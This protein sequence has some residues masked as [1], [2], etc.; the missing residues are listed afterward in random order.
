M[1]ARF[2]W[3]LGEDSR[4]DFGSERNGGGIPNGPRI[5]DKVIGNDFSLIRINNAESLLRYFSGYSCEDH[6]YESDTFLH[7][8]EVLLQLLTAPLCEN[9]MIDVGMPIMHKNVA[10]NCRVIFLNQKILLIR[11]KL[12]MCDDGNYRESRWF[13][14]WRKVIMMFDY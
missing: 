7:S 13:T 5:G 12:V 14:G 9:M 1:G 4:I 2:R 3:K 11:P 10:Y 8:W 6:F